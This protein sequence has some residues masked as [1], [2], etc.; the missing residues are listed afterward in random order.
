MFRLTNWE[1]TKWIGALSESAVA[2]HELPTVELILHFVRD[3]FNIYQNHLDFFILTFMFARVLQYLYNYIYIYTYKCYATSYLAKTRRFNGSVARV[4]RPH[5]SSPRPFRVCVFVDFD[6]SSAAVRSAV[7]FQTQTMKSVE[8]SNNVNASHFGSF[9]FS[10]EFGVDQM[11]KH[12]FQ[13]Q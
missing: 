2:S 13:S 11:S 3:F 4:R 6:F 1:K 7:D 8:I 12:S 10:L 5:L 9:H